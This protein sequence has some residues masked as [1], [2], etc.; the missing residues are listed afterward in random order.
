[1]NPAL[2]HWLAA[3]VLGMAAVVFL[4]WFAWWWLDNQEARAG[5][6]GKWRVAGGR[7]VIRLRRDGQDWLA[8]G[9]GRE[10][11]VVTVASVRVTVEEQVED[12]RLL[13]YLAAHW[14]YDLKDRRRRDARARR[15]ELV[16]E[17]EQQEAIA[18]VT[19]DEL[20]AYEEPSADG[21]KIFDLTA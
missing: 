16:R 12:P 21:P 18:V 17:Q 8:L 11:Q 9:S 3:I 14:E 13:E 4:V 7:M 5:Y 2:A 15:R 19:D 10:W 20:L 6:V 1:M